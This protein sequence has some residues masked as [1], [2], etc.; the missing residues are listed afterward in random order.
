MQ[1]DERMAVIALSEF[2]SSPGQKAGCNRVVGVALREHINVSIL[3]RPEGRVQRGT[4]DSCPTCPGFQSSP[5]QKAGC[6]DTALVEIS[7]T[8]QFQSSPG[9]LAGC[10]SPAGSGSWTLNLFQSSPGQRA[11]C[12]RGRG[13]H[14]PAH[15][16]VSILTR[17]EGRVQPQRPHRHGHRKS[18]SIL[19]RPEGRVQPAL[20]EAEFQ[21]FIGFNPHPAR[22]PGA[23]PDTPSAFTARYLWFQSSPGQKAGCNPP[24]QPACAVLSLFQS[25]PGQKA[26]CNV[27]R[28]VGAAVTH[29]V[30]ILTRPEGRVQPVV[31][32]TNPPS[33]ACFNPHPARRPGATGGHF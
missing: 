8:D 10:N 28:S 24:N 16:P 32:W 23:T 18:V 21:A 31:P 27:P 7:V 2:Q 12:N 33:C 20:P 5:G 19:I 14:W 1:R 22:R 3:T 15:C 17:P 4:A 29:S 13:G 25:S 9:L 11:G 30:S 26:G 6:N